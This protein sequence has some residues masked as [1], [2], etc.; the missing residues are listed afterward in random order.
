MFTQWD[1]KQSKQ[2]TLTRKFDEWPTQKKSKWKSFRKNLKT[3]FLLIYNQNR[4]LRKLAGKNASLKYNDSR[5]INFR[6]WQV[7]SKTNAESTFTNKVRTIGRSN[8]DLSITF[9]L[10]PLDQKSHPVLYLF[11]ETKTSAAPK[12]RLCL[13]D[14]F[15]SFWDE[16]WVFSAH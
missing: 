6:K 1:F 8:W 2:K 16:N 14:L 13:K 4:I 9:S 12:L 11:P 15:H 7:P 10:R 5:R 3:N